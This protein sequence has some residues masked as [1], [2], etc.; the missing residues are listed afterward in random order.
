MSLMRKVRLIGSC[1]LARPETG[2]A[3]MACPAWRRSAASGILMNKTGPS[4]HVR[5][6]FASI[7]L[8][9]SQQGPIAADDAG[10]LPAPA[11]CLD[12]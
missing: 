2:V 1:R 3:A 11:V 12:A 5:G 9:Q 10:Y 6:L 8:T 4:F 7:A